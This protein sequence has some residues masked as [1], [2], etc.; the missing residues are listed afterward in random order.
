M[1][2]PNAD[3]SNAVIPYIA[4]AGLGLA[5]GLGYYLFKYIYGD[6]KSDE[7]NE[8]GKTSQQ[9]WDSAKT[10]EDINTFIKQNEKNDKMN[11]FEVLEN[12]RK[13]SL[14]PDINTYNNLLNSCY[15]VSKFEI[16]DK[17]SEEIMDFGSSIQP[18][19]ST[20]NI[21]LKGISC[22]L[23]SEVQEDEKK[24]LLEK[25]QNLFE[26]VSK[27]GLKYSDITVNT[28]LDILIKGNQ[29]SKAWELFDNMKAKYEIE[30]DK[31]SYSTIIKALKIESDPSKVEK[32][33]GVLEYLRKKDSNA[34][35]EIIFN[36]LLEVCI[37]FRMINKAEQL[38]TEMKE[39]GVTPSKITYAIMIKGYGQV[40]QLEKAFEDKW[41]A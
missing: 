10:I 26:E 14:I 15:I 12:I 30:P 41:S 13:K 34:N 6:D 32:A 17:L 35:D 40:Y 37:K 24:N 36:C 27:K 21:L 3:S 22:K 11:P 39:I 16:A 4:N 9:A 8:K 5:F 7:P 18:D 33:F 2:S 29:I 31:Y 20:Y 38:F 23:E 1:S 28:M 25:A 19:I